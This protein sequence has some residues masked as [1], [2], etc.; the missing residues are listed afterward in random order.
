MSDISRLETDVLQ[1][2]L[3]NDISLGQFIIKRQAIEPLIVS[4]LQ[5]THKLCS[6]NYY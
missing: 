3:R 4:R 6:L 2:T 5:K 1:T